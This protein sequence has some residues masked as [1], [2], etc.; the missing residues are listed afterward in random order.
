MNF[1][2]W[3]TE[4]TVILHVESVATF[5]S[6]C[7]SWVRKTCTCTS[8]TSLKTTNLPRKQKST[9][10]SCWPDFLVV[11]HHHGRKV[12]KLCPLNSPFRVITHCVRC[13]KMTR[14]SASFFFF[15]EETCRV[16]YIRTKNLW[17]FLQKTPKILIKK[18]TMKKVDIKQRWAGLKDSKEE[19]EETVH[20]VVTS[21]QQ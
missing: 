6:V 5:G 16:G 3:K 7:G 15:F 4:N 21:R 1:L 17:V 2:T 10:L 11:R 20:S 8:A 19:K 12:S 14:N 13:N 18:Y 9:S